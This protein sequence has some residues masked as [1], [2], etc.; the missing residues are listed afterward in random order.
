MGLL[1]LFRYIDI[2]GVEFNASIFSCKKYKTLH[3]S[4]LT[5]VFFVLAIYK[6][7]VIISQAINKT[8]FTVTEEKDILS[9]E[10]QNI[11]TFYLTICASPQDNDT[12]KFDNLVSSNGLKLFPEYNVTVSKKLGLH[13]YSY[14]LTNLTIS[15]GEVE[16]GFAN[17][18]I[19]LQGEIIENIELAEVESL[20]FLIDEI[21]IKRS[22][23]NNPVHN[24]YFS[25]VNENIYKDYQYFNIYLQ[26]IQVKYQD[27]FNFGFL[28][29]EPVSSKNYT[30]YYSSKVSNV[31]VVI[32][33]E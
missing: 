32:V 15:A 27:T 16:S 29:Y 7:E 4:F 2:F 33:L 3:G 6:L 28:R 19:P 24:K 9:G 10:K 22:D 26:T 13:C 20:V 18:V 23:Y 14:N 11:S 31:D 12:F 21:F 5:V 30:S 1:S 25:I 8:N 17:N